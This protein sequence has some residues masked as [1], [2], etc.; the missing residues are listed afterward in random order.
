MDKRKIIKLFTPIRALRCLST[1]TTTTANLKKVYEVNLAYYI[2]YIYTRRARKKIQ[3]RCNFSSR[4]QSRRSGEE[5]RKERAQQRLLK[6]W[7]PRGFY[8]CTRASWVERAREKALLEL[9][10]FTISFWLVYSRA[11]SLAFPGSWLSRRQRR[12]NARAFYARIFHPLFFFFSRPRFHPS[13]VCISDIYSNAAGDIK[14]ARCR[15]AWERRWCDGDFLWLR[16]NYDFFLSRFICS[17][18]FESLFYDKKVKK[19]KK[20]IM[21]STAACKAYLI[22]EVLIFVDV[23]VLCAKL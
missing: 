19:L 6:T 21:N 2:L 7:L 16:V 18:A 4:A 13:R 14:I 8:A 5:R 3:I 9:S 10:I 22:Y 20:N 23:A 1:T 11:R 17:S 15:W 12:R